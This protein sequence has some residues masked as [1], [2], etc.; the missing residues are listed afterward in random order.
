MIK[1][2]FNIDLLA[3]DKF[4]ASNDFYDM[5][6]SYGLQPLILQPSRVTLRSQTLIDNIFTNNTVIV[7]LAASRTQSL[8]AA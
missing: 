1:G 6:C 3:D 7:R 5:A 2:N 8:C 4:V